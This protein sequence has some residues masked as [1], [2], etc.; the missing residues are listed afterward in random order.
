MI[1]LVKKIGMEV[2]GDIDEKSA[3]LS[4]EKPG[5]ETI[6]LDMFRQQL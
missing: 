3:E 4:L 1:R 6:G 2:D 5:I